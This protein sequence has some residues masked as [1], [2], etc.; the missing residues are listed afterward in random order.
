[1]NT[2]ESCASVVDFGAARQVVAE[3]AGGQSLLGSSYLHQTWQ[4]WID[5]LHIRVKLL[6]ALLIFVLDCSS[7][8]REVTLCT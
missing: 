3:P 7:F 8:W 5:F 4:C 1:M 6:L 2:K